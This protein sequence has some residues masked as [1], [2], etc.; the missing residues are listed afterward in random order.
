[1]GP[2]RKPAWQR[3]VTEVNDI[4]EIALLFLEKNPADLFYDMEW[5]C[6]LLSPDDWI[7]LGIAFYHSEKCVP[8]LCFFH[9][10]RNEGWKVVRREGISFIIGKQVRELCLTLIEKHYSNRTE[11]LRKRLKNGRRVL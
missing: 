7:G 6:I 3:D 4:D 11:D 2:Y 5:N 1:M 9:K 10:K 8:C